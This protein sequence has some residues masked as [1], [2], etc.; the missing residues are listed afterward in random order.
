MLFLPRTVKLP[1]IETHVAVG[2]IFL[3]DLYEFASAR[4]Q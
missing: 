3:K 2:E 4:Q 1:A